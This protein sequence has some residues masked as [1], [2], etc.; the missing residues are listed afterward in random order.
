[1][2]RHSPKRDKNRGQKWIT[3]NQTHKQGYTETS[4]PERVYKIKMNKLLEFQKEVKAI[5]KDSTNPFFKSAYFNINKLIEVIKPIVNK[6][7][8]VI[9]QPLK[10][11]DGKNVLKT[12]IIDDTKILVE[13]EVII[14]DIQD[15]QKIGSCITYLRRYS[16]QSLLLLEAEDDDGNSAKPSTTSN[17]Y[18]KSFNTPNIPLPEEEF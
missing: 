11:I 12:M 13:S 15:P 8:L 2:F 16:L 9:I 17:G 1:M 10:V 7:E 4:Q 14:P 6:L 5:S 3:S 18:N